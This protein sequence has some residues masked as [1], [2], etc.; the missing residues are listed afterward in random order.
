MGNTIVFSDLHANI[1]A[2]KYLQS[3]MDTA[4]DVW[5]LGD[6]F[7][8]GPHVEET[9][10]FVEEYIKKY[11]HW[12]L[13]NHDAYV[14]DLVSKDIKA[15]YKKTTVET[16]E[17]HAD[18]LLSRFNGN[19]KSYFTL[20]KSSLYWVDD[21]FALVHSTPG[22]PMGI[23]SSVMRPYLTKTPLMENLIRPFLELAEKKFGKSKKMPNALL[24]CGHSHYP[25]FINY[26]KERGFTNYDQEI[27][28]GKMMNIPDGITIVNPGSVGNPRIGSNTFV[29]LDRKKHQLAFRAFQLSK[30]CKAELVSD[31]TGF[32]YPY[33]EKVIFNVPPDGEKIR[34]EEPAYYAILEARENAG[35]IPETGKELCFGEGDFD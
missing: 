34:A 30:L 4:K 31:A 2:A 19:L 33:E 29:E 28:Y 17:H 35:Q 8:R 9:A 7:G 25:L 5:A 11:P 3:I 16:L 26:H 13:G 18:V 22:D 6:F 24:F 23:T 1:F 21:V 10:T 15:K 32:G 20:G 14:W 12:V 27:R